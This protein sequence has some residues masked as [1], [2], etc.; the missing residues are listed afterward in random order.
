MS[1]IE[2]D[3]DPPE[4]LRYDMINIKKVRLSIV[5]DDGRA[6]ELDIPNHLIPEIDAYINEVEYEANR[7]ILQNQ[8]LKYG[9]PDGDY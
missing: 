1:D 6:E 7:D 2:R 4:P 5:W 8:A 9:D 3:I